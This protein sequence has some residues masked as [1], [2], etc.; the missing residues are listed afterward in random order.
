MPNWVNNRV[1][2]KGPKSSVDAFLSRGAWETEEFSLEWHVPCDD[3]TE[4]WGARYQTNLSMAERVSDTEATF[5]VTTPW[6]VPKAWLKRAA[7]PYQDLEL[8]I[9]WSEEDGN[10]GMYKRGPGSKESDFW[11]SDYRY[12]HDEELNPRIV[13]FTKHHRI[14]PA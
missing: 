14:E 3:P 4:A 2:I 7:K 11:C 6:T 1:Y 9:A 10:W 12:N 8:S 5:T 13:T